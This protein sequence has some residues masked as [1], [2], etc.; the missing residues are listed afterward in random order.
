GYKL[1]L[2][3]QVERLHR[4]GANRITHEGLCAFADQHLSRAGGLFE[5]GCDVDRVAR[6]Q[7]FAGAGDDLACVDADPNL[8]AERLERVTY[9][10]GRAYRANRIILVD[11]RQAE[12]GHRRVADELLDGAAVALEDRPQLGVVGAHQVAEDLGVGALTERSRAD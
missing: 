12:D 10:D 5:P 4:H 1:A 6:N 11:L 3:L 8:Q 9:L 2:A 7:R